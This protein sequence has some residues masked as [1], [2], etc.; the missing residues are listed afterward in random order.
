M[1]ASLFVGLTLVVGQVEPTTTP[2]RA[3]FGAPVALTADGQPQISASPTVRAAMGSPYTVVQA[4]APMPQANAPAPPA[5]TPKEAVPVAP[6]A[7]PA[8][9]GNSTE[10]K[11]EDDKKKKD[12][13]DRCFLGRF[14]GVHYNIFTGRTG[15]EAEEPTPE[16]RMLPEPWSSPPFPG[17]EYQGYPLIG[18]S[19]DTNVNPLMEAVYG[20]PCG[21]WI[22]STKILLE[23]WCTTGLNFSTARNSNAPMSY[24]VVP[25]ELELDQMVFRLH[26]ELD[27]VQ[28]DHID[29]GF[30]STLMY[31][32][33]YRYMT[34][35]GWFSDQF[36]KHNLLYGWDP[37]EQYFDV[38]FPQIFGGNIIRI[39]R[40]IACPDIETQWAPDNYMAS[41]SL[42]FTVD[43]YTQTGI[44][45]T[46]WIN[47]QNMVQLG[48]NCGDDMAPWYRGATPSGFAAWRW[49]SAS[50]WTAFY[51][52]LNQINNAEFR[53]FQQ[54]GQPLGHD[55]YNYFV[56]TWEQKLTC[57]GSIHTKTEG[58][59]MWERNAEL[60]GTPSA[61]PFKPFGAG[62]GDA[63]TI[64]G[65][66]ENYG[67]LNYTMFALGK[68]CYFT[69]RNECMHDTTGF[70][71]GAP[72]WYTSHAIGLSYNFNSMLQVRPEIGYYRNWSNAVFDN[73]N[74]RGITVV[75][76]DCTYRF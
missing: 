13:S 63:M 71:Y 18:A 64:P 11:K 49:V 43:T 56:S 67:L 29:W 27:S 12:F 28:T 57:D 23:G 33:D 50:N 42:Q 17:H 46:Q 76:L 4:P 69:I 7:E 45:T 20:G 38:Y 25:N 70:R 48:I 15:D 51:S 22:K 9:N 39:G 35:G 66:S 30:R 14:W 6:T 62:G 44:M 58:Y 54:Y 37:T 19:R 24:W 61:G 8:A 21:D 53:H 65:I 26:R 1:L 60:G 52:V 74:L 34:A 5:G 3:Q 72:G 59:F 75:G 41:H 31:G 36:L 40:W 47:K 68:N 2:P 16:R 55:N 10:E 32:M 73:Y